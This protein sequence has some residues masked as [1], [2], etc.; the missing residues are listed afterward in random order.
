[1][2]FWSAALLGLLE[3]VLLLGELDAG[4]ASVLGLAFGMLVKQPDRARRDS[5]AEERF[6]LTI[7]RAGPGPGP[8]DFLPR[9]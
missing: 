5:T 6:M 4:V 1:V 2:G 9:M 7:V 8:V 3:A